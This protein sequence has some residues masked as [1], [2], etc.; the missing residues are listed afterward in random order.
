MGKKKV[1]NKRK[2]ELRIIFF[3]ILVAAALFIISTY[4]WFSTQKNVSITNLTG[5]VEVAEGLEISLNAKDWTNQLTLGD[6][7]EE[8]SL[9]DSTKGE[10]KFGPYAGHRNITPKE[11]LPVS[12]TGNVTGQKI[13]DLVMLRGTVDGGIKLHKIVATNEALAADPNPESHNSA[14]DK[15]P[16]YFAFDAFL[17][18][19]SKDAIDDILQLNYDSSVQVK[20]DG[21][22]EAGLQ[23]T[24]RVAIA[25]YTAD[26]QTT[27]T[28][29]NAL[30]PGLAP[31]TMQDVDQIL[32]RTGATDNN[33]A[34][35]YI[36]DVAIWE[37]NSNDHVSY[38]I[39]NNNKI[40]WSVADAK[41]YFGQTVDAATKISY[42]TTSKIPTYAL[43]ESAAIYTATINDIYNWSGTETHLEKQRTL[44]TTR[45]LDEE[46]GE[47]LDYSISEGV[48]NLLSADENNGEFKIPAA[49]IIRI[50][51]YVWLEG[52]DVDCIN[53]ASYGGG[54]T[55]NLGMVKDSTVGSHETDMQE[56]DEGTENT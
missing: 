32:Q 33:S 9:T 19:N 25:Q 7:E 46:S 56:G 20:Q 2:T 39:D 1:K 36:K 41:T 11:L 4:A 8:Y 50:R 12:T 45:T 6:G 10:G 28:G 30:R 24:V 26:G 55:V 5:K 44:Q 23:N 35:T 22:A 21:N 37:P 43:K 51:V 53:W 27:G 54:I 14:V 47:V 15:Y 49:S 13:T 38:I 40:T 18:N 42:T 3:I 34:G 52:Q 17:K 29:I 48:Q 31:A 16:G